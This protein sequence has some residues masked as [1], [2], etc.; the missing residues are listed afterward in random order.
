[1]TTLSRSS[2][3]TIEKSTKAIE[4]KARPSSLPK[5]LQS[6]GPLKILSRIKSDCT[7]STV[8]SDASFENLLESLPFVVTTKKSVSFTPSAS[9]RHCLCLEDY[10]AAEKRAAWFSRGEFKEIT[11]ACCKQVQKMERGKTLKDVKY[12]ARGLESYT[13]SAALSKKKNRKAGYA[14]VLGCRRR[15]EEAEQKR[16]RDYKNAS[17]STM[18]WARVVGLHD[19]TAAANYCLDDCL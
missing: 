4:K 10:T 1:M 15:G 19:Q 8:A 9:V 14:A 18:L 16:S 17:S 12:C 13:A 3:T 7:A 2:H 11:K 5:F 6:L